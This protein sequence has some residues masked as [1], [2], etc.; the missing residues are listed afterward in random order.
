[1]ARVHFLN[2]R[3]GDCSIIEHYSGRVTMID[4]CAGN[5]DE[6]VKKAE[7]DI[8]E[9]FEPS[10]QASGNYGMRRRPTNPLAYMERHGIKS[11]F[12][13]ILTH[14]DCDH[15][16]GFDVLCTEFGITNFWDNGLRKEKPDFDGS[17]YKEEDWDRYLKVRDQKQQGLTIVTRLAGSKFSFAN[18]GD[19]EGRG[20]CLDIVAPD[21]ALVKK[22]NESEDPNDGSYVIVYRSAGGKIVF[23]GDGHDSTFDY[24]LEKHSSLVSNCAVLIAPHHGRDSDR[25]HE[26]LD[27]LKPG[28]TLFGCADSAHLAYEQYTQRGLTKITNNQAGNVVMEPHS[29]GIDIFVENKKFAKTF[30]AYDAARLCCGSHYIGT[31]AKPASS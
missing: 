8:L 23:G 27:T 18:D 15:L 22:A 14:P 26:F 28:L 20:D 12:R 17:P 10:S 30:N 16:D 24:V 31:V 6:A 13:F 5:T 7:A 25:S 4:I 2:V 19:P 9:A 21:A 11:P 29:N 1:M 3:N